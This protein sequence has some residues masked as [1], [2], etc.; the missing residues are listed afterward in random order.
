MLRVLFGLVVC[1]A[2]AAAVALV[3]LRG[4]TVLDRWRAAPDAEIFAARSWGEAKVALGLA[5]EPPRAATR[6]K[7]ARPA[8]PAARAGRPATPV[9]RHTDADRAA[10][11][12][13]LAE[14]A[15]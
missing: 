15:N 2:L 13:V 10:L 1:A 5:P 4:R 14:H 7:P 6:S 8:R 12:R 11:D 9:E 3:P